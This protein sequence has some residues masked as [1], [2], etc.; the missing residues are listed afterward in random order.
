M[1]RPVFG[2]AYEDAQAWSTQSSGVLLHLYNL[3]EWREVKKS[4]IH[5]EKGFKDFPTTRSNLGVGSG[6]KVLNIVH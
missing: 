6:S 1:L 2:L 4:I 5:Y 3:L